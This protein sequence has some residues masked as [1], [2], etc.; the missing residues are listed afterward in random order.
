M[1]LGSASE[2]EV[3]RMADGMV[4][5]T[6]CSE[7]IS[8]IG[9]V[10]GAASLGRAGEL[11]LEGGRV[12]VRV[13]A[14]GLTRLSVVAPYP[15]S[16]PCKRAVYSALSFPSDQREGGVLIMSLSVGGDRLRGCLAAAPLLAS[17]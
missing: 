3:L 5:G 7:E 17:D 2:D 4:S 8:N 14:G 16:A 12:L 11:A 10:G 15:L 9:I 6:R 1:F 13:A